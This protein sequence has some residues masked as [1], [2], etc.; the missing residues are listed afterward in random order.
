M[1]SYDCAY[2]PG[3]YPQL[4]GIHMAQPTLLQYKSHDFD[5][6]P[7]PGLSPSGISTSGKIT[8]RPRARSE[9]LALATGSGRIVYLPGGISHPDITATPA[10]SV[11]G[12]LEE[13]CCG[14]G[15]VRM[16]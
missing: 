9:R 8:H 6:H 5:D 4:Y 3:F 15:Y 13:L 7:A 11:C 14:Q 16:N 2:K 1:I 12:L 10:T